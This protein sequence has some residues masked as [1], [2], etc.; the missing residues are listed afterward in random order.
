[1]PNR[2]SSVVVQQKS[3]SRGTVL[4]MPCVELIYEVIWKNSGEIEM[5]NLPTVD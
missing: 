4:V 5:Q 3:N 2:N 1:M